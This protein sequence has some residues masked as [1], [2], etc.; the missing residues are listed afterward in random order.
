M[1]LPRDAAR[2]G[3]PLTPQRW[4]QI[5]E[6]FHRALEC[7]PQQRTRLLD[8]VGSSD[9]E[10]RREVEALLACEKSAG[11][12]VR[13]VVHSELQ[14]VGY[15]SAGETV[16]HYRILEGLG[17]GGM[18]LVY[19]AEDLKLGRHVAVKFLPED[20]AKDPNTLGR[21]ERE[22]RAASALE[23]PNICPVYEF[24]EH[25]GQ[26]FL[27]MQLLEGGTLRELI[28]AAG[29]EKPPFQ[30]DK[31]LDLAIQIADGLNAAH[32][33][34]IIHRDMKPANIFVTSKGQAKILDFG[35]AKLADAVKESTDSSQPADQEGNP[36]NGSVLE[37]VPE[38]TPDPFL[39]RTGVAM[40][41]AGYMSPEQARGE[42]LDARTDLFSFGLVLYEM[43]T[44]QRAF[45]GDTGPILHEAILKQ[46]PTPARTLN[47]KLSPKLAR[48]IHKAIEKS[49]EAR[50]QSAA[51]LFDDLSNLKH[52]TEPSPGRRRSLI[53]A[54]IGAALLIAF[55][56]VWFER[57]R[58]P[59]VESVP[60]PRLRQLTI[61]SFENRVLT[62][63]ISP[64]G[65]YLAYGDT[66][67]I[68]LQRVAT[69]ETREVPLPAGLKGSAVIWEV[70]GTW[71]PD[72]TRFVVN[73]HPASEGQED[74]SSQTSSVWLVSVLGGPPNKV[75]DNAM[76]Y[77]VSP[78]GSSI[79][80]GTNK[81]KF[82]D[83]EIWLMDSQG[84]QARK[85]FDT[86]EESSLGG[87]YWSSDG[88][89]V[90][91]FRTDQSGDTLL[92]RNLAGGD[93][94]TLFGPSETKSLKD[95]SW[96]PDGRLLYSVEEPESS[97]GTACNFWAMRLDTHTGK[98]IEKPRKLT[99]WSGFCMAG[100]SRTLDGKQ[101]AFLKWSP[102]ESSYLADLGTGGTQIL[103]TRH[104]PL[105]ESADAAVGWMPDSKAIF[106]RSDRSGSGQQAIYRQSLDQDIAELV[107]PGGYGTNPCLTPDGKSLL[108][109]GVGENGPPPAKG[110]EP[111][112]RVSATGGASQRL[113][114]ARP[115]SLLTCASSPK[116]QCLIGEPTEDSKQ[117]VV[118]VL[119]PVMGRGP[120]L[121]RFALV[122]NDDGWFL[123]LSPDGTR[124]AATR[125]P[126]G[127]ILILSLGGKVLQQVRV[128]GWTNLQN[129]YWAADEKGFFV[130]AGIP[131]GKEILHV[132]LQG[133]AQPLWES[134]GGS[135][136]TEA[137]PSPDGRHLAFNGWAINSNIWMMGDF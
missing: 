30:T 87:F 91:Y 16:S 41:T 83:R 17:G 66:K 52:E 81:G 50:Y 97:Y 45:K 53:A 128:K 111:V 26:P 33:K 134:T 127:P 131:N 107:V 28:D 101:L 13:A 133:N 90:L 132:D 46:L 78:D 70:V 51:Q 77:S 68:L 119:D 57:V 15:P 27:V 100:L 3:A 6:L 20:S 130:T 58:P 99:N 115:W 37:T 35:L 121:F 19:R 18:G 48:I 61:N 29:P 94:T 104:F 38:E 124:V 64:D 137:L 95:L 32:Q 22:A 59:S 89:R 92:S 136:E 2:I 44:G 116:G 25:E 79:S 110:P 126:A 14:V 85:I 43:A 8:E 125:T 49:R 118:S 73:T 86:D 36:S 103:R 69:G 108:Y 75:R 76:A 60:Q 9:P 106:F 82:G 93:S 1:A 4:A 10:L 40:G 62:G 24:G 47:P 96:L 67:G 54:S 5:E 39:S 42:K 72:S 71:F 113:F 21:F 98:P 135:G 122:A 74:W 11:D 65:K 34:G 88:K 117:L 80:F 7:D 129:F 55:V 123:A 12:H 63:A 56:T 84:E 31:L 114:I 102:R 112:M 120:E 23:H 105:S 109:R